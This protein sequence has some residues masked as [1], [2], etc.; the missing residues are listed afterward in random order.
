VRSGDVREKVETIP[1]D[2]YHVITKYVTTE[3]SASIDAGQDMNYVGTMLSEDVLPPMTDSVTS[4]TLARAHTL[5]S[6]ASPKRSNIS[7]PLPIYMHGNTSAKASVY[8]WLD[9]ESFQAL[10]DVHRSGS[11]SSTAGRPRMPSTGSVGGS[12]LSEGTAFQANFTTSEWRRSVR[13]EPAEMVL[14]ERI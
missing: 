3:Y 12:E 4:A 11:K 14:E 13:Q 7:E 8:A 1:S 6:S 2:S 5:D 10:Q 9:P